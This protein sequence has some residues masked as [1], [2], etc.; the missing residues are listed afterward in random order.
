MQCTRC[1]KQAQ[2]TCRFCGRAVCNSHIQNM[3]YIVTVFIPPN[4]DPRSLVVADAVFC[5]ICKPQP[6]PLEMPYLLD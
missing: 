4:Q 6:R 3:N 5:G 2:A 1:E